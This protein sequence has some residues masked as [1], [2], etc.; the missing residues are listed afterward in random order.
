M[1]WWYH[2]GTKSKCNAGGGGGRLIK[3]HYCS[4]NVS[5]WNSEHPHSQNSLLK[6]SIPRQGYQEE[7]IHSFSPSVYNKGIVEGMQKGSAQVMSFLLLS[8]ITEKPIKCWKSQHTHNIHHMNRT[9]LRAEDT[10]SII[11]A[12]VILCPCGRMMK[13]TWHT[14][15]RFI[16]LQLV[17]FI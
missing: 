5:Y 10:D 14:F 2:K 4:G 3:W 9:S 8:V 6:Y 13:S 17:S 7:T 16:F 11:K 15:P 12:L 1:W